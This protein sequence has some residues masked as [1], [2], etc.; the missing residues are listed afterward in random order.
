L[1]LSAAALNVAEIMQDAP[2]AKDE[3]QGVELVTI[4]K[5]EAFVPP[6]AMAILFN[7]PVPEFVSVMGAAGV[8]VPAVGVLNISDAAERVTAGEITGGVLDEDEL[9]PLQPV[10]ARVIK[11]KE[12]KTKL[13]GI[14]SFSC[15]WIIHLLF[16]AFATVSNPMFSSHQVVRLA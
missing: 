7:V 4:A 3:P 14:G 12:G 2:A 16:Y 13:R 5:S 9:E 15:G 10:S 8:V 11:R 1:V 6:S